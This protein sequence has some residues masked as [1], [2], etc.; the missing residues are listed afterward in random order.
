MHRQEEKLA[1]D[2]DYPEGNGPKQQF[3]LSGD[4]KAFNAFA[5]LS[6]DPYFNP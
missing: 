6:R 3:Q 4:Q 2:P 5:K 1:Q